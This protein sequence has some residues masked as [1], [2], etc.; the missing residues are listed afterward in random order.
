MLIEPSPSP[1]FK[2]EREGPAK[3]EGEVGGAA[4]RIN[5]PLHPALPPAA[6]GRRGERVIR[7]DDWHIFSASAVMTAGVGFAVLAGFGRLATDD[8]VEVAG[9]AARSFFLI[10]QSEVRFI[11]FLEK[12]VPRDRDQVFI[13]A[14]G[15]SGDSMRMMP[16]SSFE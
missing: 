15:A 3:R 8:L 13:P 5:R 7:S 4:N 11:E 12:F 9:L 10:D 2:A 1:P 14:F 6:T 16:G